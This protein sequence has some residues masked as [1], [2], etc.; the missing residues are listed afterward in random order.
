MRGIAR[1]HGRPKKQAMAL[2]LRD[3]DQL[4][5]YLK[6][7]PSLK[8]T[9]D[10]ALLLVGFFGAFRCSELVSLSWEQVSF[11]G[12]GMILTLPRSKTDQTG[13]GERCVIPI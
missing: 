7:S 3:L 2:R 12:E 13:E 11:V 10:R 1:L 5:S 4:I 6:E 9:R 8:N